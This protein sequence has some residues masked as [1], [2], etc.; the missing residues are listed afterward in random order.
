MVLASSTVVVVLQNSKKKTSILSLNTKQTLHKKWTFHCGSLSCFEFWSL[1]LP[2]P[3]KQLVIRR[4][5]RGYGE[6][7]SMAW[8]PAQQPAILSEASIM[9]PT[10][11][12]KL[13]PTNLLDSQTAACIMEINYFN[14]RVYS[15]VYSP[16]SWWSR[17]DICG[18]D[19][20]K[21]GSGGLFAHWCCNTPHPFMFNR[22]TVKFSLP[23][24]VSKLT[25][26][27]LPV[28]CPDIT[29][30]LSVGISATQWIIVKSAVSQL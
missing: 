20:R 10:K 7:P 6:L 12:A 25:D 14:C 19:T 5:R 24:K 29:S 28:S 23:G 9:R 8:Q 16:W 3:L 30:W 13:Y 26:Y 22:L 21:S 4:Q 27:L 17:I 1:D 15:A 18:L 2:L 11:T